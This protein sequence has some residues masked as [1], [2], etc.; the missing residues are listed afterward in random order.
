MIRPPH[1]TVMSLLVQTELRQSV[2]ILNHG[3]TQGCCPYTVL[4]TKNHQII[5]II[6]IIIPYLYSALHQDL[7]ALKHVNTKTES[8]LNIF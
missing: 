8:T 5:I 7:K 2:T 3:N 6:I 4:L 1:N